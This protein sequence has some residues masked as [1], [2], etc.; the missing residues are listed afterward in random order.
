MIYLGENDII[1]LREDVKGINQKLDNV[2]QS[3]NDLRVLIVG[4]YLKRDDFYDFKGNVEKCILSTEDKIENKIE[5]LRNNFDKKLENHKQ[6]LESHK[7]EE[8]DTKFKIITVS[9]A[10]T[11]L[12]FTI[13]QGI[14]NYVKQ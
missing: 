14:I 11:G 13:I 4:E 5:G 3:I 1:N 8:K 12:I 6:E 9:V 7:K 10:I 2:T